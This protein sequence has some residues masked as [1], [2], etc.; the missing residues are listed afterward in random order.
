MM[1]LIKR[2]I[3]DWKI[4]SNEE[5]IL[6]YQM[7]KVGSTSLE[8]SIPGS[9]HIHK[10]Y[11]NRHP[12]V[13]YSPRAKSFIHKLIAGCYDAMRRLAIRRRKKIKIITLVRDIYARNV[14]AFFQ[15]F[16]FWL[17]Q[18]GNIA[19]DDLEKDNDVYVNK[20]FEKVFDHDYPYQWFDIE[21][22]EFTHIDVFDY[23]FDKEKGWSRIEKGKYDILIIK[24]ESIAN[25]TGII[26]NFCGAT[27]KLH[28]TNISDYKWYGEVYKKFKRNYVPTEA[29]LN[30]LYTSKTAQHFYSHQEITG[31]KKKALKNNAVS[32]EK[33]AP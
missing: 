14:S 15:N 5:N 7:G 11:N 13:F 32:F 29:Y 28:N 20:V 24:L 18:Y 30:M 1:R 8:E 4:F 12:H 21:L 2:A 10:L 33:P 17:V 19:A 31:F 9:I 27:L 23:P 25:A 22:K 3:N 26:E 6:I 16:A